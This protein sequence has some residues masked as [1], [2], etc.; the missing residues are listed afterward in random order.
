MHLRSLLTIPNDTTRQ[1][2]VHRTLFPD[3]KS[4]FVPSLDGQHCRPYVALQVVH[5]D[6]APRNTSTA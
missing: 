3:N 6:F 1:L 4:A 5:Y 2:A